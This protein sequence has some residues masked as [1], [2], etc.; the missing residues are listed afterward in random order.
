MKR[1]AIVG[2][3]PAGIVAAKELAALGIRPTIFEASSSLGGLW[4]VSNQRAWKSLHTNLSKYTCGFSDFLW[5]ESTPLFP[6]QFQVSQYLQNYASQNLNQSDIRY[7]CKVTNVSKADDGKY[8]LS[9]F[10]HS[11][12]NSTSLHESS[13][14]KP[15]ESDGEYTELF[16]D[17]IIA[18]GFFNSPN[19]LI[20]RSTLTHSPEEQPLRVISSDHYSSPERYRNR[21]VAVIGGSFSGMEIASEVSTTA[22]TVFHIFPRN[23]YV[24]PKFL[25]VDSSNSA[26]SFLPI[27]LLFYQLNQKQL[28]RI[29]DKLYASPTQTSGVEVLFKDD[30]EVE[31]THKYFQ[32]MLGQKLYH[33]DPSIPNSSQS[34][35]AT[36]QKMMERKPHV[37]ISDD[38]RQR[39]ASNKIKQILGKVDSITAHSIVIRESNGNLRDLELELDDCIVCTGFHPNLSF[40]N[41]E[42][43][44]IL[45]YNASD[46]FAPIITYRDIL[47]KDLPHLYFVG[48]YKGPYFG[49][50]ELQAVSLFFSI[51]FSLHKLIKT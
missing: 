32:R 3:G 18:T 27:D 20:D 8:S 33:L 37:V 36:L 12:N 31:N 2:G 42:I 23:V 19:T 10:N 25:P 40:L 16:D 48:M 9:W 50:M 21:T 34:N 17:V 47:H 14:T 5:T 35:E 30:K 13:I 44:S 49:V 38:Y 6:S 51:Q 29:E 15:A 11:A 46:S 43:L 22:K 1:V 45:K 41:T 28:G 39:T 4:S 24:I 7:H 26:T